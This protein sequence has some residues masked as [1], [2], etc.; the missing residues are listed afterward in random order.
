MTQSTHN[1]SPNI[2]VHTQEG[3]KGKEIRLSKYTEICS[4]HI[5]LNFPLLI[6]LV[7]KLCLATVLFFMIVITEVIYFILK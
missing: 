7:E 1:N 6:L 5:H 2:H 3:F 4:R